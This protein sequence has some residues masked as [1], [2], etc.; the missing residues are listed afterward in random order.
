MLQYFQPYAIQVKRIE[1][2]ENI[3]K[4]ARSRC[5]DVQCC[6]F[7]SESAKEIA[8][9]DGFY[10][11]VIGN[12][13]WARVPDIN[14]FVERLRLVFCPNGTIT[15]EFPHLMRLMEERQFDTIY[16]EHFHHL[17]L[18]TVQKIF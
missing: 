5:I 2:A 8:S 7:D 16:Y 1:P 4:T 13:K 17:P 11:L 12:N 10:N 3:A 9:A 14:S 18:T 15:M 6:F